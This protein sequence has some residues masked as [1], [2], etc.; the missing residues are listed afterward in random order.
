MSSPSD[1][2]ATLHLQSDPPWLQPS[3]LGI[4]AAA[5]GAFTL[6][7]SQTQFS[8]ALGALP[9]IALGVFAGSALA[10]WGRRRGGTVTLTVDDRRLT[11]VDRA[12]THS[13]LDL[14]APFSA[15]LLVDASSGRRALVVSQHEEPFVVLEADDARGGTTPEAWRPATLSLDLSQLSLT[16]ASPR[17]VALAVGHSLDPVLAR[18]TPRS[19]ALLAQPTT[20]GRLE[21]HPGEVRFGARAVELDGTVTPLAYAISANGLVV[22]GLGLARAEGAVMLFA[23]ED[24]L[25]EKGAVTG[26]L[27]P[28]AYVPLVTYELLRAVVAASKR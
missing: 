8:P 10:A 5:V 1:A 16:P 19:P 20:G 6:L 22:A 25:V 28:D 23:C 7:F 17:V 27:T 12:G 11:V 24:A 4:G 14:T 9:G 15:A 26:N 21:L 13:L 3:V 2:S 18:V